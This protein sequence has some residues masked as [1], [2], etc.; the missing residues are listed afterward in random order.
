MSPLFPSGGTIWCASADRDGR[1]EFDR[2][3]ASG[4]S[5]VS[6]LAIRVA[7]SRF[8]VS[9]QTVARNPVPVPGGSGEHHQVQ[10]SPSGW[11]TTATDTGALS[12]SKLEMQR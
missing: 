8:P 12:G 1:A 3:E 9:L 5:G 11:T 4:T 6:R 10:R 2:V 7:L